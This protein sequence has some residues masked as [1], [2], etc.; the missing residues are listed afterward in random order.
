MCSSDLDKREDEGAGR[1]E[2]AVAKHD[3]YRVGFVDCGKREDEK[4]GDVG[5]DVA[6]NYERHASVDYSGKVAT[7][8][9]EFTDDIVCLDGLSV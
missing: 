9:A 8:V 3:G 5:E 6:K 2:D 7:W 1:A 4:V